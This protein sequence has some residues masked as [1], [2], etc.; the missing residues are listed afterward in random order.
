MASYLKPECV[1]AMS[2][3]V[4]KYGHYPIELS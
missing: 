2:A 1:L 4:K 3:A